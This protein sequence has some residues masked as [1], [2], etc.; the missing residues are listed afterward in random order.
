[1]SFS[2]LHKNCTDALI[3]ETEQNA[4]KNKTGSMCLLV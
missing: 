2:M 4:T 3:A 1:M